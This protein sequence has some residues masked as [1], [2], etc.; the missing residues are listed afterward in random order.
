MSSNKT[1]IMRAFNN[2]FFDFLDDIIRI[3]PENN[4]LINSKTSFNTIKMANPSIIIKS[5]YK[6]VYAPYQDVIEKGDI[7]F[8]F[9]KDYSEDL[10]HL[11]N[12]NKIMHVIDSLREPIKSMNQ[13]N[14]DHSM[15]Y[16]QN[17]S[18]LSVGY[19]ANEI[20]NNSID[21]AAYSR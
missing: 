8:F 11:N 9:E 4:D 13:K 21:S 17:L 16:I 7:S 15:K 6:F 1:T 2:H 5:W 19:S 18:K 3:F 20:N 12:S 14:K 10:S